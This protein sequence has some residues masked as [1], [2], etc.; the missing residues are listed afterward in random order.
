M[1]LDRDPSLVYP[2]PTALAL[3][4]KLDRSTKL[5][6][7]RRWRMDALRLEASEA[8]GMM[9]GERSRLGEIERLLDVFARHR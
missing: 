5:R 8:E 4:P 2:T 9:G 1:D 6:L 3:D 7:L